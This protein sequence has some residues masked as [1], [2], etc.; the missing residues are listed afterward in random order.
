MFMQKKDDRKGI[1]LSKTVARKRLRFG[2][3]NME[4]SD[5]DS[6]VTGFSL[7]AGNTNGGFHLSRS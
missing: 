1:R 4:R 6:K 7:Q 2:V 5:P 3:E